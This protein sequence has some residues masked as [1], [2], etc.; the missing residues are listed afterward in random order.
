MSL[1]IDGVWNTDPDLDRLERQRE[2]EL[3][4]DFL[5]GVDND[6]GHVAGRHASDGESHP[7]TT[8]TGGDAPTPQ[9]RRTVPRPPGRVQPSVQQTLQARAEC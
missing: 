8:C 5:G 9:S 3:D 6:G 4:S 2:S 7:T 1:Q